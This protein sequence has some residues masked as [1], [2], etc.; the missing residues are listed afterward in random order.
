MFKR[1]IE[2]RINDYFNSDRDKILVIDGARQI[3]K[4]YIVRK[5]AKE[6]FQNYNEINLKDDFN[7]DKIFEKVKTTRDFY[8]Q[9]SALEKSSL[10]N[11]DDTI[12]FLDEIQ[13][14]P[15]LISMLK[16][17]NQEKKYTYIV[18]G[19]LL[20][21]TLR[22]TF[23]PMG[24]IDEVKMYP[25]DFEEFLW[26]N[27]VGKEAIQ[28]IRDNF[29]KLEEVNE[30]IHNVFLKRFKEY[31]L[32]GGLPDAVKE[33]VINNNIMRMRAV[34]V[35]TYNYYEDDCSQYDLEHNLK[36]RRIYDMLPSYMEN[37]VKRVHANKVD[38]NKYEKMQKYENEFEY[39]ISSGIAL[40]A[41]AVSNPRFPLIESSSKNLMKLYYN[42][43]GLL[44]NIL[45]KNNINAILDQDSGI[46]LG[47]VYETVC[48]MEL[49]A[50]G[51]DLYYFDSKKVG[52]VDFLINGYDDLSVLPIEIKSGKNQYNYRAIPKL[53]DEIGNYKLTKGYIFGNDNIVNRKNNLII[54]PIYMIMFI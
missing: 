25:M 48:A 43:V 31:L 17:L 54:L 39:L 23:I 45:F 44:T 40:N 33:F 19:S 2:A 51:H 30:S 38:N 53:V 28:Y 4:T 24:S 20:G 12:I 14:Y 10:N 16:P 52:E 11:R 26:A 32:C 5:L 46:N 42:D 9:V 27:N 49:I 34:H 18:S 22:H 29:N 36:I 7:G 3:G 50:H 47:S 15:H 41:K 35:Q 1:K 37:K 6:V 13:V 21:I 8:I